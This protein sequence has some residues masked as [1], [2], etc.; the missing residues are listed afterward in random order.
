MKSQTTRHYHI[1]S[2]YTLSNSQTAIF[3]DSYRGGFHLYMS[4]SEHWT[5]VLTNLVN[6]S[7]RDQRTIVRLE[8]T[9]WWA[10]IPVG[11]RASA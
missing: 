9:G 10:S 7:V 5:H 8:P 2:I 11:Y 4:P 1:V 6:A 3:T